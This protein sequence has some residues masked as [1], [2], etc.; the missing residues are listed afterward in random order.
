[1]NERVDNMRKKVTNTPITGK[2]PWIKW[3]AIL[4]LVGLIVGVGIWAWQSGALDNA[5]PHI[6]PPTNT[7]ISQDDLLKKYPDAASA[8]A[9]IARGE[10]KITDF[11]KTMQ[12]MIKNA[13]LPTTP[14]PA[15]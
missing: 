8:K 4:S 15:H 14:L 1:M 7:G 9:G 12:D 10:V 3:I 2:N 5:L 11:P 6:G 13:K